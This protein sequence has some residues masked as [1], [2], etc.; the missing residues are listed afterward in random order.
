MTSESV[1][2]SYNANWSFATGILVHDLLREHGWLEAKPCVQTFTFGQRGH[3]DLGSSH[4]SLLRLRREDAPL[5]PDAVRGPSW[6][7]LNGDKA[8]DARPKPGT[9][10]ASVYAGSGCC[11][12][13]RLRAIE[14]NVETQLRQF[15]LAR[16]VAS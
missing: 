15:E 12:G 1:A 2:V 13:H 7:P 14:A 5:Y 11:S 16:R 4:R 8:L 9:T 6:W 10:V 3:T